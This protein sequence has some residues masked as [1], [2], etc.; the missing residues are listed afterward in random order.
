[1][2]STRRVGDGDTGTTFAVAARAVLSA[3]DALPLAAHDRL[4]AAIGRRLSEIMG[5]TSG[6]LMSI[7]A[8][9][10]G[11]ALGA[12][13]SWPAALREGLNQMRFYGGARAGRSHDAGC[14][15]A[16][17]GSAGARRRSGRAAR[18]AR[19]GADATA[20]MTKAHAGRSSYLGGQRTE[21]RRR[22][23]RGR[24]RDGFRGRRAGS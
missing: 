13:A 23:W 11:R 10:A 16:G 18:A 17:G 9:A 12:G 8:A 24:D 15:D 6:V 4:C 2:R 22:S 21:R 19:E 20:N 3:I 7:F 1:M 14:A 5:G